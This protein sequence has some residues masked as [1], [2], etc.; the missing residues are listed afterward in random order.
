MSNRCPDCNKFVG[1]EQGDPELDL[2][3]E[4]DRVTG[5]VRLVLTCA[6]CGGEMKEANLDIDLDIDHD[7]EKNEDD[8]FE[9]EDESAEPTDRYETKDRHGKAIKNFRYQKHFYGAEISITVRCN[10]CNETIELADAVEE[11]ASGFDDLN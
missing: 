9:I 8:D 10:N 5:Y 1:L 3:V 7:C 4:G 6:D 2:S 11:Q